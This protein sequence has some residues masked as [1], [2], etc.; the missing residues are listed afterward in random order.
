MNSY[1]FNTAIYLRLSRDDGTSKESES[2]QN[3]KAF[4]TQYVIK[5]G[6][7]LMDIY[8][9]DGWSGTNFDRPDF[10]RLLVDIERGRINCVITKDLSRLG[11][12][13]IMTG[14]YLERYFPQH[15]VRY[16]AVNDGID[17]FESNVNNDMTPFKA[18]FNDMYAK[19]ISRKVRTA[20]NTKKENGLFI[21]SAAPYGYK[22]DPSNKGHLIVDE[23]TAVIVKRIFSMYL[24]GAAKLGIA[25]QLSLEHIPTP[26][27]SKNLT[28]TQRVNK[29][30]WNENIIHVIL[31]NPT[32]IGNLAQNKSRK[33]NYKIKGKVRL[34]KDKWIVVENTHEPIITKEDFNMVQELMKKRTYNPAKGKPHL[35]SG[36]IFCSDCHGRM[37]FSRDDTRSYVVCAAWRKHAK[38]KICTSHRIREDYLEQEV[39]NQ[40]REHAKKHLNKEKIL[41]ASQNLFTEQNEILI[42]I[43]S[44][45]KR[46]SEITNIIT[47]LYVDKT[48][49]I[50]TENDFIAIHKK[51]NDERE[52]ITEQ[53]SLL[54][55]QLDGIKETQ[56]NSDNAKDLLEEFL[57]FDKVDRNIL[58]LLIQK[59]EIF[60]GKKIKIYFNFKV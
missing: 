46:L 41:K 11:R 20:L 35:L 31:S 33:I 53:I 4:L 57:Q 32:Y 60:E 15:N 23:E 44:L 50:I 37:T 22:K 43:K 45:E 38:L 59:I 29:G 13:Y 3:Q 52:M 21:G 16:I 47:N 9:D 25:N 8:I 55:N 2:I 1:N 40:L 39:I 17:T 28:A 56:D 36:M 14:H 51:F 54:N 48:K 7:Y 24:S 6:F 18:V 58:S 42:N 26:S 5:N 12:D 30:V 19:D 27:E 49:G 34:P 10:Q